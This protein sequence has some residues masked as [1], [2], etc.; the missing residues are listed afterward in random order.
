MKVLRN[1]N[2]LNNIRNELVAD[3]EQRRNV[4]INMYVLYAALFVLGI[5]VSYYLF[6]VTYLIILPFQATINNLVWNVSRLSAYIRVFYEEEDES[7]NWETMNANYDIYTKYL[8][9]ME[10][11]LSAWIRNTSAAQL[12]GMSTIFFIVMLIYDK[13]LSGIEVFDIFLII[14]S[15]LLFLISLKLSVDYNKS[16]KAELESITRQYKNYLE[17]EM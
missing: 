11:R 6:L 3:Q 12:G 1:E 17:S 9:K 16:Y 2:E 4:W 15:V 7:L 8:K 13:H 10:G 5:Q 14:A